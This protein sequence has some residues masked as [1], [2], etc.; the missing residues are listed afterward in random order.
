MTTALITGAS[1]GIGR[2]TAEAL[3]AQG[4]HVIL[5]ARNVAALEEVHD[6][7]VG[8]G[9]SATILPLDLRDNATIDALGL[10][11]Y[12]RFPKLDVLI[13][14]AGML[15]VL[16]PLTHC[17]PAQWDEVM[18][19][20]L[21]A[22]WRLLRTLD[23]LLKAAPAAQVVAVTSGVTHMQAPYW[24]PY[25]ISKA[26]LEMLMGTYAAENAHT[27]IRADIFDPGVASTAMRASAFPGEDPATLP[28]PESVAAR[29]VT[30]L[31]LPR[32]AA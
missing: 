16:T 8:R 26:G 14:N 30:R 29:L 9:G 22:N 27:G 23:P 28:T 15:G 13:L 7:I 25:A 11:L 10:S 12:P 19:V 21:T 5:L 18:Q 3:A 20:N 32:K 2:A 4:A 1:R 31:A 6:A 17:P 24:G